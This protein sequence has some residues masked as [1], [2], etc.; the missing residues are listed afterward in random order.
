MKTVFLDRD[1]VINFDS[2]YVGNW[3]DFI[4]L[5][6]AINGLRDLIRC[7]F[8]IIIV[9]NQSGIARGFYTER[10]Y[11]SLEREIERY[12][13]EKGVPITATYHCP[14]HIEGS[15]LEYSLTCDCRKPLPGMLVK[16]AS[17]FDVSFSEAIMIGDRNSDMQ[18]AESAG[19]ASRYLIDPDMCA[20]EG[21]SES[22]TRRFKSLHDSVDFIIN[23]NIFR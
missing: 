7:N 9:T 22:S 11:L 3:S 5:P 1:G 6:G 15:V 10:E 13:S 4:F 14:H 17:D 20:T 18:A 21:N 19:I 8:Q 23:Q 12:L 2:G 16:A